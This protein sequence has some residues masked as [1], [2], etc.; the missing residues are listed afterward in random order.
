[1]HNEE[2]AELIA[3]YPTRFAGAA[4]RRADERA[5]CGMPRDIERL[6]DELRLCAVQIFTN[7]NGRPLD[8]PEFRPV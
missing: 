1:M 7:V 4:R 3:K 2:L 6:V 5:R 8:A